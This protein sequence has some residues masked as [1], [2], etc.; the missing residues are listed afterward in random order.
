MDAFYSLSKS[1]GLVTATYLYLQRSKKNDA[2]ISHLKS[3]W[4]QNT[5]ERLGIQVN[6]Q[7][8][9]SSQG[10][11]LLVGNHIS[12]V[13]IPL[14]MSTVINSSFVAKQEL[15]FWPVFGAAAKRIDTVFVQRNSGAS[16]KSARRSVAEA[17]RKG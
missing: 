4:A 13:D 7:G 10:S 5:L 1:M 12:Y 6:V 9:P 8:T 3:E 2:R 15:R 14:L 16:R 11:L 17:L